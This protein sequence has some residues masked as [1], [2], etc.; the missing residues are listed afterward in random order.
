M[1]DENFAFSIHDDPHI[2][3]VETTEEVL[4][5]ID[6]MSAL[7]HPGWTTTMHEEFDSLQRNHTW[8]Y[9]PLPPSRKPISAKWVFKTKPTTSP[10]HIHLKARLVA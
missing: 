10:T 3:H 5:N 4:D 7:T 9:V 2:Y 8:D 6:L 1:R